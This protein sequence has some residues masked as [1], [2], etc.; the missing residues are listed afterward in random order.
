M[1]DMHRKSASEHSDQEHLRKQMERQEEMK[2]LIQ[3]IARESS[4]IDLRI[5]LLGKTGSGKSSAGNTIIGDFVFKS[6]MSS[7]SITSHCQR[8]LTTVEDRIISVID[9]PGMFDT[10]MSEEQLKAEIAKCVYMS[11]PGPHVFLLVMRLDARYTNEEKNTVKWIQENFGEEATRYTI[12]LFTRGDQLKGQTLDDYISEN[13]DLKALVNERGDRYHLFN[14]EDMKNRSQ[15]TELLEKIEK[16]VKENGGQH[17]TNETYRKAQDEIKWEAQKQRSKG[18]GIKALAVIG[19]ATVVAGTG[20]VAVAVAGG[21]G[22]VAAVAGRAAATVGA[23]VLG[24]AKA[25]LKL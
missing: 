5:V 18:Y 7:K 19:G 2:G 9:T 20:A 11:A 16:M 21:A 17:Y 3:Q 13:N 25:G 4:N 12:I 1:D 14:N 22:A 24:A 23:A 8:H 15:V 10:Y 6:G